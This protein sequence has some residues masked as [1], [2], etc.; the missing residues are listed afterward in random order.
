MT[1]DQANNQA[2]TSKLEELQAQ[3]KALIERRASLVRRV[4]HGKKTVEYDLSAADE[5]LKRL[6]AE[7]LAEQ[8]ASTNRRPLRQLR[9]SA[10]RGL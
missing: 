4:S 2:A 9:V 6:D 3:R 1:D 7:I 8:T 5:A 10:G